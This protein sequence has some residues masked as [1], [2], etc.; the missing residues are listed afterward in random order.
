MIEYALSN[1]AIIVAPDYR[2]IPEA[3]GT[4][5]L[6]D[7]EAF[8]DWLRTFLPPFAQANSWK[9]R[10]D[11]SRILCVGQS[12]GGCLAV[13][14]ALIHPELNIKAVVTLYSPLEYD[15]PSFTV[16]HPRRI[17]GTMP[18][19]PRQAEAII[20][21]YMKKNKGRVR[22]AGDPAES[23]DLLLAIMQQGRVLSFMNASPGLPDT[24]LDIIPLLR[25]VKKIPPLWL[26]HGREDTVVRLLSSRQT[27]HMLIFF[28]IP[29]Q[30]SEIFLAALKKELPQ[31]PV[32]FSAKRGEHNFETSL[33]MKEDWIKVGCDFL[34]KYW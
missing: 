25:E 3:N 24:R 12:T 11:L 5:I 33:T 20:R 26:I 30:C 8:W 17:L 29:F 15:V 31:S 9:A 23:W 18:P 1:D 7:I 16:P 19:P 22:T 4:E 13:Q 2:L 27:C 6:N 34:S 32:I 10:P 21:A 14:S 28:Q